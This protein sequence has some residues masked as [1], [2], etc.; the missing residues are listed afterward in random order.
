MTPCI[1]YH[2]FQVIPAARPNTTLIDNG[3]FSTANKERWG[4]KEMT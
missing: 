4:D 2:V 3:M 1:A